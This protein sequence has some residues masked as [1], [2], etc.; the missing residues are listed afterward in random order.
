MNGSGRFPCA[1]SGRRTW[2]SRD[3]AE[4]HDDG[5]WLSMVLIVFCVLCKL[6]D[7]PDS[8]QGVHHQRHVGPSSHPWMRVHVPGVAGNGGFYH[9]SGATAANGLLSP[10]RVGQLP[11]TAFYHPR[12]G[13]IAENGFLSPKKWGD[14]RKRISITPGPAVAGQRS[15]Q[16]SIFNLNRHFE[17]QLLNSQDT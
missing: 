6:S 16:P 7:V 17:E 3:I 15:W 12:S 2:P 13:A 11:K 4:C 1:P 10:E 5:N 14:C 8:L 9:R